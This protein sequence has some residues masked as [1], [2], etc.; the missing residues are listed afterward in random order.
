[1]WLFDKE[2]YVGMARYSPPSIVVDRGVALHKMIRLLTIG[3]GGEAYLNFMGNEFGH[4]EWIDFPREGNHFSYHYCRRHWN[5]GENKDLKYSQL[6]SFDKAFNE[7]EKKFQW[8]KQGS[9]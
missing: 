2:I 4:P 3:L 7:L 9:H 8:L 5:L 1:M 6:K